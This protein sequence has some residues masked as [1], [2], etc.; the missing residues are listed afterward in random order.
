MVLVII[1]ARPLVMRYVKANAALT[2]PQYVPEPVSLH[3]V[4][5]TALIAVIQD[6]REAVEGIAVLGAREVIV[7][8]IA[9]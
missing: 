9:T 1:T 5:Q 3:A 8:E 6:V 4:V 2:V 7:L